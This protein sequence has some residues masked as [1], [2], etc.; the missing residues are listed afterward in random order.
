MLKD[1]HFL[2]FK[3]LLELADHPDRELVND[4]I[5]GFRLT[6]DLKHSNIFKHE[7]KEALVTREELWKLAPTLRESILAP[8]NSDPDMD[9]F[10]VC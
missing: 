1:K 9:K 2:L 6:G 10:G 5:I 3:H 8:K 4:M 7:T